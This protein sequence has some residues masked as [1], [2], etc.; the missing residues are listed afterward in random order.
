MLIAKF[1]ATKNKSN[2]MKSNQN[3]EAYKKTRNSLKKRRQMKN[4][5]RKE[6]LLLKVKTKQKNRR[7]K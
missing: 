4:D 2:L 5:L 7:R 1:K 3:L 6:G